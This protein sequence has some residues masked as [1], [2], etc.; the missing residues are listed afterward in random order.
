MKENL[1][2]GNQRNSVQIQSR[3]DELD[4]LMSEEKRLHQQTQQQAEVQRGMGRGGGEEK[5]TN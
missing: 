5:L 3:V 2:D 4:R 1:L